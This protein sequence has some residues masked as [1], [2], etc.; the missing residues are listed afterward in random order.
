MQKTVRDTITRFKTLRPGMI[1]SIEV[2]F[3]HMAQGGDGSA[4]HEG[5]I[6]NKYYPGWTTQMFQQVCNEMGWDWS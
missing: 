2:Q 6:R 4:A 3:I 5:E 1:N